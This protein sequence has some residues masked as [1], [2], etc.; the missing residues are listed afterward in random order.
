MHKESMFQSRPA[1]G[2][3]EGKTKQT[4]STRWGR[5]GRGVG[6][7]LILLWR[8]GG[9]NL[10]VGVVLVAVRSTTYAGEVEESATAASP[11]CPS[12]DQIRWEQNACTQAHTSDAE[13]KKTRRREEKCSQI[14][15]NFSLL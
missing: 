7:L 3:E 4:W 15:R 8:V 14:E 11:W 1:L 9:L 13:I 12:P 5:G 2:V 10:A 6:L